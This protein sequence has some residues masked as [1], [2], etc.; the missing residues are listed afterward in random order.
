[1][2]N[3]E[4]LKGKS[5]KLFTDVGCWMLEVLSNC[6]TAVLFFDCKTNSRENG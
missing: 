3:S 4:K 2:N 5:E 1:M 6:G